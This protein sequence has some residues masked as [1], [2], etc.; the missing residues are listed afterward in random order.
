MNWGRLLIP[1]GW[2]L[3]VSIPIVFA[4]VFLRAAATHA[5]NLGHSRLH[6]IGWILSGIAG[7]LILVIGVFAIAHIGISIWRFAR[8]LMLHKNE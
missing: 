4:G 5:E 2:I 8:S 3:A 1:F 7:L 6:P